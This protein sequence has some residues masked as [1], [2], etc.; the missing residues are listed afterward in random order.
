M[1]IEK[2]ENDLFLVFDHDMSKAHY[3][4]FVAYVESDCYLFVKLYPQQSAEVR[5]TLNSN[6]K[7]YVYCT[8]NGLMNLFYYALCDILELTRL[9]IFLLMSLSNHFEIMSN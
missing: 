3:P 7:F 9:H 4:S 6:G 8:Q 2:I 5:F 1:K